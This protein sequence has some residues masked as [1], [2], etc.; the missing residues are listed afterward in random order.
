MSTLT[1]IGKKCG[2]CINEEKTK[3]M[4]MTVNKQNVQ[5]FTT[6]ISIGQYTF[7]KVKSFIYL[8]ATLNHNGTV[9]E[10]ISKR[11]ITANKAYYANIKLLKSSLLSRTTKLKIYRTLIR[12]VITYA[13]ETWT[14]SH[15]DENALRIF[16]RK[17]IRKIY[18]PVCENGIWRV[19]SN[20]EIDKILK[21][22]D[23]VRFVKSL[24]LRWLGHV[25]RMETGRTPKKLLTGEII[26]VRRRGRPRTR[27]F[28]D[29]TAD[30]RKMR[31]VRW[32]EKAQDRDAWRL[33]V[34]E[35][36]AHPGL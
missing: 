13:A 21:G 23:L 1:E 17:I 28:Q 3:Y 29:V 7:E 20:L 12:P 36:K 5:N 18:G 24:R 30:L 11:I 32:K 25:E 33:I 27:W 16:E 6:N 8:G 14:L 26:G 35:A 34:K 22:E 10:E 9:T 15:S 4:K 31:I 19:R 2:L